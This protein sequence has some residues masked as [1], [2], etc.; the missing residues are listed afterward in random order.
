MPLS[1]RIWILSTHLSG[2][3]FR[4]DSWDANLL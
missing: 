4:I 1:T 3:V 2:Q